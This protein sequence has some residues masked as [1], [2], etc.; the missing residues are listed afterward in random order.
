MAN[1]KARFAKFPKPIPFQ[2][3]CII[4]GTTLGNITDSYCVVATETLRANS[5][6]E[7]L[8]LTFKAVHSLDLRYSPDAKALWRFLQ[9]AVYKITSP[10][11]E[12]IACLP[13]LLSMYSRC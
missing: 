10:T 11:D 5:P 4:V 13:A 2:P 8:D 1:R 7:A 6:L 9:Q 3:I 12:N